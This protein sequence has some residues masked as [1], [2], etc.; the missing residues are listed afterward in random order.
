MT[1]SLALLVYLLP[2]AALAAEANGPW[3]TFP[4]CVAPAVPIESERRLPQLGVGGWMPK[5][6]ND[7]VL[8]TRIAAATTSVALTMIGPMQLGIT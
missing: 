5:P 3:G 1:R 8:S 7:S 2:A 6:R 4:N